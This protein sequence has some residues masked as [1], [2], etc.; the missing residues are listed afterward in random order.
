MPHIPVHPSAE[1]RHR[2]SLKRQVRNR[3]IKTRTRTAAKN[4]LETIAG[5]DREA[6]N[7]A[8]REAASLLQKAASRGVIKRN[9]AARKIARLSRRF[10]TAHVAPAGS[11]ASKSSTSV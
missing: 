3:L 8:L 6:A 7:Q 5:K 9:T 10:H 4:A 2:Q 1:K 11:A